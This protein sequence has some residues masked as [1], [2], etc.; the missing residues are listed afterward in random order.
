MFDHTTR[1][2]TPPLRANDRRTGSVAVHAMLGAKWSAL[3]NQWVNVQRLSIVLFFYVEAKEC[4]LI[5]NECRA[6]ILRTQH[7]ICLY[8]Y[9]GRYIVQCTSYTYLRV[10]DSAFKDINRGCLSHAPLVREILSLNA[11]ISKTSKSS[12]PPPGV[13][14]H[15]LQSC[16]RPC[17]SILHS[18]KDFAGCTVYPSLVKSQF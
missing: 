3:V 9:H 8:S 16:T 11:K 18:S 13:Y 17:Q 14:Y 6:R 10:H 12:K 2:F 5:R 4:S 1:E 7:K 15:W